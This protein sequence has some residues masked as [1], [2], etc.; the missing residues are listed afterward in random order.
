MEGSNIAHISEEHFID[1]VTWNMVTKGWRK[2]SDTFGGI[3]IP[4]RVERQQGLQA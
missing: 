2:G 3:S 1:K 4:I